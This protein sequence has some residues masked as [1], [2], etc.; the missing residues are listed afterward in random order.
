MSKMIE[1]LSIRNKILMITMLTVGIVLALLLTVLSVVNY[2]HE[3]SLVMNQLSSQA[4]IIAFNSAASL[5][6]DYQKEATLVL[7]SLE[8]NSE[9]MNACLYD[10][11]GKLFASY[12]RHQAVTCTGKHFKETGV[13]FHQEDIISN[14]HVMMDGEILGYL[15]INVNAKHFSHLVFEMLFL[16]SSGIIV[17]FLLALLPAMKL[18]RIVSSPIEQLS[19][20]A[21]LVSEK[22]D[23][24]LRA[25]K[26]S[27]DELGA[28]VDAFNDMLEQIQQRDEKLLQHHQS[29]E[30]MVV[31]RT[32]QLTLEKERA[33]HA[34]QVKSEFLATMSHE[35]RTPMNGVVGMIDLLFTTELNDIQKDFAQTAMHSSHLLINIINDILDYSKIEAGKIALEHHPVDLRQLLEE[36]TDLHGTAIHNKGLSFHLLCPMSVPN[37]YLGSSHQLRQILNNLL[38]NAIKFTEEGDVVLSVSLQSLKDKYATLRFEVIDSGIG[39]SQLEQQQLFQPFSQADSSTTRKFGGTGLGLVICK[40]LVELMGGHIGVESCKGQGACFWFEISIDLQQEAY[41]TAPDIRNLC[42]YCTDTDAKNY[43]TFQDVA[44]FLQIPF[45][46]EDMMGDEGVQHVMLIDAATLALDEVY[47]IANQKGLIP[48]IMVDRANDQMRLSYKKSGF[49]QFLF[50]PIHANHLVKMLTMIAQ[51][52]NMRPLEA[53]PYEPTKLHCC[54]ILLVEDDLVNQKVTSHMLKKMTCS[55]DIANNGQE[56]LSKFKQGTYDLVLMDCHMPEMDGY[57]ATARLLTYEKEKG[58]EHTPIIALTANSLQGDLEKCLAAGMDD[59]LSKPLNMAV[60]GKTMS[61][62]L[63]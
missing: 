46:Q 42:L 60:L 57:V 63:K 62:W 44:Q 12:I 3:R 27:E 10:R 30:D 59:Y 11:E 35:I 61:E 47:C 9:I 4:R 22:R 36:T 13:F 28:L 20:T 56:A 40:K 23:Y 21:K 29:L 31:E 6:F 38:A 43:Q 39:M 41:L 8:D 24:S 49:H 18:Q 25:F 50:T 33:E 52:E 54:R 37:Y 17:C 19:K 48:M 2:Y 53:L 14:Q 58:K 32:A 45:Q 55:V 16:L 7:Q 34:T 15:S 5:A 51:K 1:R 26:S